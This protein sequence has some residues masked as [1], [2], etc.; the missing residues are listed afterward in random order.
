M[1]KKNVIYL[2]IRKV[3]NS[4]RTP[5]DFLK[6]ILRNSVLDFAMYAQNS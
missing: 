6:E 3:E 4:K 2:K 5:I 1:I